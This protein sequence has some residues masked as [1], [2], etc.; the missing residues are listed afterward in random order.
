MWRACLIASGLMLL[1]LTSSQASSFDGDWSVR[2][3]CDSKEDGAQKSTWR[4]DATVKQG[5]L[6][7][8]YRLK[9]QR[10]SVTLAGNI[11]PD[12]TA[13]LIAEGLSA[14]P[15]YNVGFA[16]SQGRI[17]LRV[18]AKFEATLGEGRAG[19]RGCKFTFNKY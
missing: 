14:N 2:Q 1:L 19:V 10:P 9:G 17:S 6:V 3:V 11:E 5:H 15:D 16:S 18:T 12:G 4:Y 13:T 8:Q 7:G